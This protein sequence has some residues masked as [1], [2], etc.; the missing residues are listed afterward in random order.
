MFLLYATAM[1]GY[2]LLAVG[3]PT[4]AVM[5]LLATVGTFYAGQSGDGRRSLAV[6]VLWAG[7]WASAWGGLVVAVLA[8]IL[9]LLLYA[10][11]VRPSPVVVV[12]DAYTVRRS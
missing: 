2:S 3:S 5:A 11:F 6:A 9:A 8:G 12:G 4:M 7:V 10:Q 1:L